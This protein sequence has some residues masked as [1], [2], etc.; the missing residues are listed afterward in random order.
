MTWCAG[1]GL[2]CF[3]LAWLDLLLLVYG[4]SASFTFREAALRI[5]ERT[6]AFRNRKLEA[7]S[8]SVKG[9]KFFSGRSD[10]LFGESSAAPPDSGKFQVIWSEGPFLSLKLPPFWEEQHEENR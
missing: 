2:L 3:L 7:T 9:P 1:W 8:R 10:S 5:Q 6:G 4:G